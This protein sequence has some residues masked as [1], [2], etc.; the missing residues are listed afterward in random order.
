[1]LAVLF[2]QDCL[3]VAFNG[4][5]CFC[6]H[7]LL[8]TLKTLVAIK[9][10]PG[11]QI[12]LLFATLAV[13]EGQSVEVVFM[14]YPLS[15]ITI[16]FCFPTTTLVSLFSGATERWCRLRGNML[17]YF[18]THEAWSEPAG[19][20]LLDIG[21]IKVDPVPLDGMWPF[22]LGSRIAYYYKMRFY[23]HVWNP[24]VV[25]AS[26]GGDQRLAA[27][28]ESIRDSWIEVLHMASYSYLK[29]RISVLCP[30]P[31]TNQLPYFFL[32]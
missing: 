10:V 20:I 7:V 28:S 2:F 12:D 15:T 30:N 25:M 31:L 32:S 23:N 19:V 8:K 9:P 11:N 5:K 18:K 13:M 22:T 4:C 6:L 14:L 16:P 29:V 21:N 17:F 26:G 27:T 3:H 24:S 1:M